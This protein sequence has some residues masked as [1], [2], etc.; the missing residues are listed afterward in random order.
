MQN[1]NSYN[2]PNP[3][4]E[5]RGVRPSQRNKENVTPYY[6]SKVKT[7]NVAVTL[8]MT[9]ELSYINEAQEAWDVRPSPRKNYG[10]KEGLDTIYPNTDKLASKSERET[11]L[12]ETDEEDDSSSVAFVQA[13]ILLDSDD[14]IDVAVSAER[15]RAER[16]RVMKEDQDAV[17][18][19]TAVDDDADL[20]ENNEAE[21]IAGR[22][23]WRRR[24][25]PKSE[26]F[27]LGRS[28]TKR[29]P[30]KLFSSE[31]RKIFV[32]SMDAS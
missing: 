5:A 11:G 25:L 22:F 26:E 28:P 32:M 21:L 29:S 10:K 2:N 12:E 3:E 6:G 1:N 23:P 31:H 19:A 24:K 30:T 27:R 9:G 16:V 20:D 4:A 15:V 8:T 18:D 14:L 13:K 7:R 17:L